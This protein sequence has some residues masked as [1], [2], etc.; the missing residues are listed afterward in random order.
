[1]STGP[2][3]LLLD[4]LILIPALRI[5]KSGGRERGAHHAVILERALGDEGAGRRG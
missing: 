5:I 3:A 4:F 2:K 1:M